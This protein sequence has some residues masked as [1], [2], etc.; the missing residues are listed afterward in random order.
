MDQ[1]MKIAAAVL[2]VIVL[3]V[4]YLSPSA[5]QDLLA[6]VI[7]LGLIALLLKGLGKLSGLSKKQFGQHAPKKA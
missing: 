4:T 2:L 1:K 6:G 5:G 7:A 3:V